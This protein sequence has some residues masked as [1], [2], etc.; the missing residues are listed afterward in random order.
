MSNH[1]SSR[2]REL[3]RKMKEADKRIVRNGK[4]FEKSVN[5]WITAAHEDGLLAFIG[6]IG[7]CYNR[8]VLNTPEDTG[9][10]RM[11]WHI[12]PSP[13]EWSPPPGE[14][15]DKI[16]QT[17]EKQTSKLQSDLTKAD[18]IYI[19]NNVEYI[20]PLE[21]GHSVQ[22]A[23]FFALFIA[24]LTAQLNQAAERSRRGNA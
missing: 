10:A 11:G 17:I 20:K 23:G 1:I 9:R 3:Q 16:K 2:R 4:D 14:Y 6:A 24:E 21:A 7:E 18:I 22:G 19:M 5:D 12:E 13:D 15:K 8:L